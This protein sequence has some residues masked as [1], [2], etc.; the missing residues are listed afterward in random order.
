MDW[1]LEKYRDEWS[2]I[3][4]PDDYKYSDNDILPAV[5]ETSKGLI[6]N[7]K[8]FT[9]TN[10]KDKTIQASAYLAEGKERPVVVYS[11]SHSGNKS[12]GALLFEPLSEH[13]DLV[14]FDY[15]GYG[16][17]DPDTCTLGC[18]EQ[19]DL[20]SVIDYVKTVLKKKRIFIWGRSQGAVTAVL[21]SSRVGPDSS[22]GMVLDS[23]FSSTK[24]ML[25]NV[26]KNVPKFLMQGL[27]IPLGSKLQR[28]TGHDI[29]ATNL[30]EKVPKL[31]IPTMYIVGADDDLAG[32]SCVRELSELHKCTNKHLQVFDGEH[33]SERPPEVL[34]KCIDFL[35]KLN[36]KADTT[37][38]KALYKSAVIP[39]QNKADAQKVKN[40]P[41]L[42]QE[43][44]E[45][46]KK[47]SAAILAILQGE[48]DDNESHIEY[49]INGLVENNT[50]NS[51]AQAPMY[52]PAG[53]GDQPISVKPSKNPS[54]VPSN[55]PSSKPTPEN[56]Q[57]N[58][59]K[60]DDLAE[61]PDPAQ[62]GSS[63]LPK[64][65]KPQATYPEKP[66]DLP[67]PALNAPIA[68]K[69]N[70]FISD[71]A[72]GPSQLANQ[73]GAPLDQSSE[74]KKTIDGYSIPQ[75]Q[76]LPKQGLVGP[77]FGKNK[78]PSSRPQQPSQKG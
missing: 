34:E 64:E 60:D 15:T 46:T 30:K 65:I 7:R 39:S 17:S 78:V 29:M 55:N 21:Y 75:E 57:T 56:I 77:S 63:D 12:E 69:K 35:L 26:M 73:A 22:L 20:E 42:N 40:A 66:S 68:P 76:P 48:D 18:K 58:P 47:N 43:E 59:L 31:N 6:I 24:D 23:P 74:V 71:P 52:K 41:E 33:N 3:I 54:A 5:Y 8:D 44:K 53:W 9:L 4:T 49:P 19:Y 27:F 36:Q 62:K 61:H 28:E 37:V 1:V 11:H 45:V 32:A 10:A 67:Q 16:Y 51:R 70:P 14:I 50:Q 13:F 38:L 25:C 72:S 2:Q